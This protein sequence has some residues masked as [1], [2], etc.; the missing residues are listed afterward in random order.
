MS[1]KVSALDFRYNSTDLVIT[2]GYAGLNMSKWNHDVDIANLDLALMGCTYRSSYI[3]DAIDF[4]A[5]VN[6]L[7]NTVVGIVSICLKYEHLSIYSM[8][9]T[10]AYPT[11]ELW[12]NTTTMMRPS[13]FGIG[14]NYV[15]EFNNDNHRWFN[16]F[17]G[18]DVGLFFTYGFQSQNGYLTTG[19]KYYWVYNDFNAKNNLFWGGN[20]NIGGNYWITDR[21]G[22]EISGGYKM[23]K[24]AIDYKITEHTD[25]SKVGTD[26]WF[27]VDYSGFFIRGGIILTIWN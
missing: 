15:V 11:G 27:E 26:G 1:S 2:G 7:F 9:R 18:G 20:I 21:T 8:D 16:I 3:D 23:A 10:A 14:V 4:S 19:D 13:Y 12:F 24:G 5:S 17:L 22:F 25:A 6:N